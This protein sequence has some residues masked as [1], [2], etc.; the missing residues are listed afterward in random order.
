MRMTSYNFIQLTIVYLTDTNTVMFSIHCAV[1]LLPDTQS[2]VITQ[3]LCAI[4]VQI[5]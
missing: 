2:S 1:T 5:L 3:E 4:V